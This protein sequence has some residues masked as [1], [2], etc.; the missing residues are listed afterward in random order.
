MEQINLEDNQKELK[1]GEGK[2]GEGDFFHHQW[3]KM[4]ECLGK[5]CGKKMG[6]NNPCSVSAERVLVLMSRCVHTSVQGVLHAG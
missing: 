5:K 1:S 6:I 4:G 3:K 2:D